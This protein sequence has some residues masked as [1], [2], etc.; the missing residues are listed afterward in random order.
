MMQQLTRTHTQT[1]LER[2]RQEDKRT[3]W[4]LGWYTFGVLLLVILMTLFHLWTPSMVLGVLGGIEV[5]SIIW[6]RIWKWL[7][8]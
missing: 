4:K 3:Q 2:R 8:A 1:R 6:V 5:I 7:G